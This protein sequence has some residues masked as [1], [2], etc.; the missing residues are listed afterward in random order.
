MLLVFN[1]IFKISSFVSMNKYE[2][3]GLIA[4]IGILGTV[5]SAWAIITHQSYANTTLTMY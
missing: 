5:F 3:F 1:F 2:F 4:A